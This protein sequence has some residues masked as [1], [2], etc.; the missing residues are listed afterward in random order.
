MT[1]HR[2]VV[3]LIQPLVHQPDSWCTAT[4]SEMCVLP[5]KPV[6]V[7]FAGFGDSDNTVRVRW[8]VESYTTW[9]AS[10][11]A[12]ANAIVYVTSRE[13]I[14]MPDPKMTLDRRLVLESDG[15]PEH[16]DISS[17]GDAGT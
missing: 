5:D 6:D 2:A 3:C 1:F 4:A 9:R 8:W 16:S 7:W 10:T 14:S 11:D 12:V 17:G 15:S 13:G